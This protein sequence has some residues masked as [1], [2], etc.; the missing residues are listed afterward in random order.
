MRRF[1]AMHSTEAG[2]ATTDEVENYISQMGEPEKWR[3][4]EILPDPVTER[5]ASEEMKQA[6]ERAYIRGKEAERQ[7]I[8]SVLGLDG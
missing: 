6:L 3:V 5:V 4:V 8:R 2:F 7:R 1:I